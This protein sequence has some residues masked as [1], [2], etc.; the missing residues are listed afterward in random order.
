[1]KALLAAHLVPWLTPPSKVMLY[2]P[3]LPS[4]SNP[5]PISGVQGD[6]IPL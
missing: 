5:L 4:S 3:L 1:L 6:R 2:F